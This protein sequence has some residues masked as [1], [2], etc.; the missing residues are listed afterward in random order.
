MMIDRK[1]SI[2]STSDNQKSKL[3]EII[4]RIEKLPTPPFVFQQ[5]MKVI[6]NPFTSALDIA[7]IVSED[8]A[9]TARVLKI[10]NSAYY[11]LSFKIAD[12]KHAVL[13][14]GIEAL[15]SL[16]LSSSLMNTFGK[17]KTANTEY[18]EHFWRHSL[19]VAY[20]ARIIARSTHRADLAYCEAAFSA[21]ILHD[22]GKIILSS[23]L[24][25]VHIEKIK[26]IEVCSI[27]EYD[28]EI[29]VAGCNHGEIGFYLAESWKLP[30]SLL[31][32][33]AHHHYP[34]AQLEQDELP[35]LIH[36]SNHLIHSSRNTNAQQFSFETTPFCENTWKSLGLNPDAEK[37]FLG[38]FDEEYSHAETFL[39][40]GT[41]DNF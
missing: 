5:M 7:A 4:G 25:D 6:S 19:A 16:V 29:R 39:K 2:E 40:I 37:D 41:S 26:C 11:G 14:I 30:E 18:N 32:P 20:L 3:K 17:G 12:V 36:L 10:T 27:P 8:A 24:P 13:I 33:I 1:P 38:K 35:Y 9:M 15:K 34:A 23:Y 22:I 21:G 28:A 31:G